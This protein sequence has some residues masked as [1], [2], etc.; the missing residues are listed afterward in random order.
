[1]GRGFVNILCIAAYIG[2]FFFDMSEFGYSETTT[3]ANRLTYMF[4]HGSFFHFA[5]N[6]VVFNIM[7]KALKKQGI[8]DS[9]FLSIAS[10]FFATFFSEYPTVTIGLSG[11]CF[12]MIGLITPKIITKNRNFAI[13][14]AVV[15]ALQVALYFFKSVNVLNH[16]FSFAFACLIST[17]NLMIWKIKERL[18]D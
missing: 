14:L 18:E 12:A 9:V 1:M 17:I 15:A 8:R 3:L 4:V 7:C 11:V 2:S 16:A 13:S 5:I 10:A 6:L